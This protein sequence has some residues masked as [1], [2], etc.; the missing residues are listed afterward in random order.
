MVMVVNTEVLAK[1]VQDHKERLEKLEEALDE[2]RADLKQK[3]IND[4]R[5]EE[6]LKV[7]QQNITIVQ[8]D[9]KDIKAEM[10]KLVYKAIEQNQTNNQDEKSFYR[11]LIITCISVIVSII[12]SALGI[13]KLI[14]LQ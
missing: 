13:S 9:T 6:I 12:L 1:E 2:I 3:S 8:T 4:A 10:M 11:K 5:I 14:P 7:V